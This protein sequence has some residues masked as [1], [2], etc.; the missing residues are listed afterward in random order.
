MNKFPCLECVSTSISNLLD[1]DGVTMTSTLSHET[2][3]I[4]YKW[5]TKKRF[6]HLSDTSMFDWELNTDSIQV[7]GL[8]NALSKL[9]FSSLDAK[10]KCK[11]LEQEIQE[12]NEDAFIMPNLETSEYQVGDNL[13]WINMTMMVHLYRRVLNTTDDQDLENTW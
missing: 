11:R 1:E 6:H 13:A 7:D 2:C 8:E 3:K 4:K 12:S 5:I 10:T 9:G